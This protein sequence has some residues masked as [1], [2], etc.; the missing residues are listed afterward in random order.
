MDQMDALI[1]NTMIAPHFQAA[2]QDV[3]CTVF[4]T[5]ADCQYVIILS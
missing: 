1:L 5:T 4:T 2:I 3:H